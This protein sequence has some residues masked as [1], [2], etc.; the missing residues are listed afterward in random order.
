MRAFIKLDKVEEPMTVRETYQTMKRRLR[1][2]QPYLEA[3]D[4]RGAKALI[5]KSIIVL[6]AE[7]EAPGKKEEEAKDG[8]TSRVRKGKK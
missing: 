4:E 1:D 6:L 2:N 3:T 5:S 8:D 7:L